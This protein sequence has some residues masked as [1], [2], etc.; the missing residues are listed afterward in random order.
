MQHHQVA[1][2]VI[3]R[4]S[5]AMLMLPDAETQA[6]WSLGLPVPGGVPF[7]ECTP[8]QQNVV[9]A[10][11]AAILAF[12]L[13]QRFE[14]ACVVDGC[15]I[16]LRGDAPERVHAEM[17]EHLEK[18]HKA[19]RERTCA[20]CGCSALKPCQTLF[21][22]CAWTEDGTCTACAFPEIKI[23]GP[24]NDEEQTTQGDLYVPQTPRIY[25]P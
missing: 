14:L 20:G 4:A 16:T 18:D 22:N 2:D 19:E 24:E 7:E 15:D 21:G 8:E 13:E 12:A 6:A 17:L 10:A 23:G 5:R 9:R 1:P 25:L 11:C 3:D